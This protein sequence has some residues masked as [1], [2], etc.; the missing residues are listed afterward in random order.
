MRGG[1]V[2]QQEYS[3]IRHAIFPIYGNHEVTKFLLIGSIKFFIIMALTLTRDTKD[4]LVVTQCGAEAIAFLKIYG[5]LPCAAGFIALYSKMASIMGKKTLF[6]TTCIPFFLFFFLFDAIIYPNASAIQPSLSTVQS[7]LGSRANAGGGIVANILANWTSAL[8]YIVSEIYSSVSVG[9]L[10][11][12]FANDVVSVDQARRFYPLFAQMSGFAP[13]LA[14][15]YV[16]RFTSKAPDF[17]ESFHRVT[18]AVTF[19]GIMINLFYYI[20]S[21]YVK[22]HE[23]V[24]EEATKNKMNNTSKPKKKSKPK[25]S[26]IQ[27]AKFLASSEYLRMICVLV[28]G[29]GLSINL[30]EITWKSLLKKK[31]PNA[32]DYQRFIGNFSSAVGLA[33]CIVIFFGVQVIRF[34]GWKIGALATPTLMAIL[35]APFFAC[36]FMGLSDSPKRL[37]IAVIIGTILSLVS[38]T[39]K[40][41]LFDPTTQM[42]YIPLDE[43]SKVKGKAAIDVFGSRLGKSGGSLLQQ[44][45]VITFGTILDAAPVVS[46]IFYIVLIAWIAAASRL[47]VLFL[48]KTDE[49][50]QD[51]KTS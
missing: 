25:M 2:G 36:I 40:Y 45:L 17:R 13:I 26:L 41:S 11:W 18:V 43:E 23:S 32:L 48:E 6:F 19:A 39:G 10:F 7:F 16:V 33:T 42:A 1:E 21:D 5:V 27:S 47:S 51:K 30:T 28:V 38:K 15:Q 8:F 9:L 34:L 44:F 35:A 4:T 14:G 12:Q 50:V 29:Y 24:D 3:K 37:D 20:S 49:A 46:V 31:Y 22:K